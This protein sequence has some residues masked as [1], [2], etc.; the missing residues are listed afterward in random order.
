M[1]T[2]RTE[3]TKEFRI[4]STQP[5]DL[6]GHKTYLLVSRSGEQWEVVRGD[7][8]AQQWNTGMD[9]SIAAEI[10]DGI[11]TIDWDGDE[12]KQLV[13]LSRRETEEIFDES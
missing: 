7:H 9:V 10:N 6:F 11:T 5:A 2:M 1:T 3:V 8:Q 12:A 4:V 13:N